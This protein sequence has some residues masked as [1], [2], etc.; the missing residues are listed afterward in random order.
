[1]P[2]SPIVKAAVLGALIDGQRKRLL[3][4]GKGREEDPLAGPS[5]EPR[6]AAPPP[7][8]PVQPRPQPQLNLPHLGDIWDRMQ[9]EKQSLGAINLY[10]MGQALQPGM[11]GAQDKPSIGAFSAGV[12]G[13]QGHGP[14]AGASPALSIDPGFLADHHAFMQ[15]IGDGRLN[16]DELAQ[17]HGVADAVNAYRLG[18]Q[19]GPIDAEIHKAAAADL[20][21]AADRLANSSPR[22]AT[23]VLAYGAAHDAAAQRSSGGLQSGGP[24]GS[25]LQN[26]SPFSGM[27]RK[28]FNQALKAQN[29]PRR[30]DVVPGERAGIQNPGAYFPTREAASH[31]VHQIM[32]PHSTRVNQEYHWLY[33]QNPVSGKWG[34]SDPWMTGP[35]GGSYALQSLLTI[36]GNPITFDTPSGRQLKSI[37]VP[38]PKLSKVDLPAWA[39]LPASEPPDPTAVFFMAHGEGHNHGD[40]STLTGMRTSQL[41]DELNSDRPSDTDLSGARK[42]KD[43]NPGKKR[44]PENLGFDFFTLG[45]PSKFIYQYDNKG[46]LRVLERPEKVLK[47]PN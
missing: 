9:Q 2:S 19:P 44:D 15:S 33:Y 34:F 27:N 10:R 6:G 40:Y 22:V 23:A 35:Q 28:E 25:A 16:S 41:G 37:S 5:P 1:M 11:F 36:N 18:R 31:Y 45:T 38:S 29:N 12:G 47:K 7:A 8:A 30:V 3:D 20:E 42:N 43:I 17:V 4:E 39:N 24:Q 14:G 21:Q 13:L 46:R 32:D 26:A